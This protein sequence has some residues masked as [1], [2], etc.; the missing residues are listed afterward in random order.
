MWE[1]YPAVSAPPSEPYGSEAPCL[2]AS[3]LSDD[4]AS[5]AED[6]DD[7]GG[8]DGEGGMFSLFEQGCT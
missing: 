6:E 7:V 5:E 4:V 3:D 8:D 1:S 2:M